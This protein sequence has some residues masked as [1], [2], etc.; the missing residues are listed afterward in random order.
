MLRFEREFK[1]KYISKDKVWTKSS[2]NGVDVLLGLQNGDM[3]T[4]MVC[5]LGNNNVHMLMVGT[6]GS[7]KSNWMHEII[8]TLAHTYSPEELEIML[9][10]FKDVEFKMY[11]GE[12]ALPHIST[13]IS[14]YQNDYNLVILKHLNKIIEERQTVF[15][16]SGVENIQQFNKKVLEENNKE[17]YMPQIVIM[18]DEFPAMFSVDSAESLEKI[19]YEFLLISRK[20]RFCGIH[21]VFGAQSVNDALFKELA[22]DFSLRIALRCPKDISESVIG[23]DASSK[24]EEPF[25]WGNLKDG[26][27]ITLFRTPFISTECIHFYI[28]ELQEKC[29]K[30]NHTIRETKLY[31][32]FD[33]ES[34]K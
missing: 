14:T 27:Q 29:R 5:T 26:E 34:L 6:A 13:I 9:I 30:E 17:K 4:P 2:M 16:K 10:D 11:M 15:E 33:I 31:R 1:E 28:R 23:S 21:L 12:Y 7:G 24:I 32:E 3:N 19:K 22:V 18:V 25:G 8:A 20:A